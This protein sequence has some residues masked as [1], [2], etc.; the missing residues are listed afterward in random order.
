VAFTQHKA[1][2]IIPLGVL[3]IYVQFFK[4]QVGEHIR[5]GHTSAGMTAFGSVGSFDNTHAHLTGGDGKLVLFLGCHSISP[6]V[7]GSV[8]F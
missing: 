5:S 8:F 2:P 3:G 1:I 4:I 6:S 7:V